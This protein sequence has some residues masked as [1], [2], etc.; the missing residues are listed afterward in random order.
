MSTP[1]D[2]QESDSSMQQENQ[3]RALI[4]YTPPH[5]A[6]FGELIN[7]DVQYLNF[8]PLSSIRIE[9]VDL[10]SL[11]R[12]FLSL[13]PVKRIVLGPQIGAGGTNSVHRISY[14]DGSPLE[15]MLIKDA[16]AKNGQSNEYLALKSMESIG[17]RSVA[18][19]L[20]Q[21]GRKQMLVMD[22]IAGCVDSKSIVGYQ[23]T[24][25]DYLDVNKNAPQPDRRFAPYLR[26]STIRDLLYGWNRMVLH[27][28]DYSDY[29]FL[30]NPRGE[31][32]YNDPTGHSARDTPGDTTKRVIRAVLDTWEYFHCDLVAGMTWQEFKT[33]KDEG[34]LALKIEFSKVYGSRRGHVLYF[35]PDFYL[36]DSSLFEGRKLADYECLLFRCDK[37]LDLTHVPGW[38]KVALDS[39]LF[40]YFQDISTHRTTRALLNAYWDLRAIRAATSQ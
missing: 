37:N 19:G 36:F 1:L 34:K 13:V 25:G 23:V 26:A 15:G 40:G 33:Y 28:K 12:K 2:L 10:L 35:E 9:M 5:E 21:I 30:I 16:G 4:P 27:K 32:I 39:G 6:V 31:I 17:L 24:L 8:V 7:S 18:R 29:Q 38:S 20:T 11:E 14:E 22:Y 3:E